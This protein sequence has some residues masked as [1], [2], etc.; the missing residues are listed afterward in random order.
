ML[1]A[2]LQ[3][4]GPEGALCP[5]AFLSR[6]LSG[7]KL[8]WSPREKECYAFFA[9]LNWHAW[10]G[11]KQVEHS[12]R[13][14]LAT[15]DLKTAG[16]FCPRQ[17]RWHELFCKFDL[18]VVYT[19][20]PVNAVG[21]FLSRWAYPTNSASGDVSIHGTTQAN[22]DVQDMM[23]AE[24]E[25]LL[26]RPLAFRAV[27]APVVTRSRCTAA[28]RAEGA[29]A[30]DPPALGLAQ[31]AGGGRSKGKSFENRTRLPTAKGLESPTRRPHLYMG[32]MI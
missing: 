20:G 5:L 29:P 14:N 10:G 8:N 17:A 24:K 13:E 28:P 16:G 9:L 2:A 22:G 27:V 7:S 19:P 18:H 15:E 30:C 1:G 21:D 25:E 23:V 4:D 32:T 3:Q 11:K 31:V 26:A 12:S 6:I